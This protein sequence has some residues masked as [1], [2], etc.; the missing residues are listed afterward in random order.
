VVITPSA[1]RLSGFLAGAVILCILAWMSIPLRPVNGSA[2]RSGNGLY[3]RR[4]FVEGSPSPAEMERLT[5]LARELGA[6]DF[7]FHHTPAST[8]GELPPLNIV[9]ARRTSE[10]L[11]ESNQDARLW[12]WIGGRTDGGVDLANPAFRDGFI[13]EAL[14]Q[15]ESTGFDGLHLNFEPL[16]SGDRDFIGL[17]DELRAV[18]PGGKL[19]SVAA[20]APPTAL[21][22]GAKLC[23]S[24][25]YY[26][27]VA[28]RCDQIMVMSYD[29]A[30]PFP[31]W[32]QETLKG[33]VNGLERELAH[34]DCEAVMGVPCYGEWRI[35]HHPWAESRSVAEAA[36]FNEIGEGSGV[37]KGRMSP[38]GHE[39][40]KGARRVGRGEERDEGPARRALEREARSGLS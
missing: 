37:V 16:P 38:L 20:I 32:Y 6:R 34:T 9:S 19:V 15:L 7:Y 13:E 35:Y 5:A 24:W 31:R 14:D 21:R 22:R 3:V 11:S 17:L 1:K 27:K 2:A 33:W 8:E 12:L 18:L 39:D 4:A 29:T 28:A 23:W 30:I 25:E 40:T 36:L 10:F 26:R